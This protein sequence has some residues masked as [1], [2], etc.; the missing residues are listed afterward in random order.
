[1]GNFVG[2]KRPK[3]GIFRAKVQLGGQRMKL[4]QIVSAL[5]LWAPLKLQEDYDNSGLLVGDLNDDIFSA[6]VTLD[7]TEDVVDEAISTGAQ[8]IIAHHPIIFRG[9]KSFTGK[10]YVQR[11]VMKAIRNNIALYAIHTNLDHIDTG[12]NK[13][14]CDL[15]GVL[16]PRILQPKSNLLEKLVVFVPRAQAEDVR[17][18]L[19]DAG[20]GAIGNYDECSFNTSGEGTFRP[21]TEAN[22]TLGTHLQRH[23][24]EEVK[25][26][27]VLRSDQV[28]QVLRAMKASHPYEEVAYDRIRLQ[29]ETAHIG[30]G[31]IGSLAAPM[32][33]PVFFDMLKSVLSAEV[34]K[35]TAYPEK[36]VEQVAVCGGAGFFL[37]NEARRSGADVFITSDIKYHEFFDAEGI[38]L[39]D[40]GHWE[41][42]HRTKELIVRYLNEKFPKFAVHLSRINTNPVK[43][44]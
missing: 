13:H 36:Q 40:V 20:A 29:N 27:V 34:I 17:S 30:A 4:K 5:E 9:L 32:P 22:P 18:A 8:L 21:G 12:V 38:V 26:E 33:W 44:H 25:V 24:E 39:A 15:L 31:M 3:F 7:C 43:Y 35:H 19:F 28:P 11:T 16:N 2:L 42:E 14:L 10:N 37:L 41:S 23:T 6:L 1:M